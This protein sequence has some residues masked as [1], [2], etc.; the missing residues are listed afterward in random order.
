MTAAELDAVI[1]GYERQWGPDRLP[2]LVSEATAE[3]FRALEAKWRGDAPTTATPEALRAGMARAFT[4]MD[5]EA[6][7]LGHSPAPGPLV[8][9]TADKPHAVPLEIAADFDHARVLI[10]RAKAEGR[11]VE[12]YAAIEVARLLHG[13]SAIG[14]IKQHWPDAVVVDGPRPRSAGGR[15]PQDEIPFGAHG[16][17]N[18]M[19]DVA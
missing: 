12:V 8:S 2:R 9:V 11:A 15:L 1:A 10:L 5:A 7:T 19:E 18:S 16:A 4:A 3:K 13:L 14:D 6:R 17:S